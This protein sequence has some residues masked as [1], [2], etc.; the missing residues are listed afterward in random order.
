MEL[1]SLKKVSK[2]FKDKII[3]SNINL[4]V[5]EGDILGIVGASGSGKSVLMKILI[6]FLKQTSGKVDKKAKIGFSIQNNSLYEN[7]TLKQNLYY[8]S[9]MYEVNNKK[10]KVQTLLKNLSLEGYKN[11]LVSKLSGGTKKRADIACALLNEPDILILDE[12]F[13]GLDSLLIN[14]LITFLKN[15]NKEGATIIVFSHRINYVESLCKNFMFVGDGKITPIS[16][17]QLKK[18]YV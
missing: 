18:V 5:S 7:L 9:S 4:S 1:I 15:L 10:E 17:S 3:L 8:F 16:K 2:K 6:G 11:V 12:P 13:T 14:R